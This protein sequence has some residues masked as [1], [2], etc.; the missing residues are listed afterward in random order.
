MMLG[1]EDGEEERV[2]GERTCLGCLFSWV[3]LVS[4]WWLCAFSGLVY[5]GE[6][7]LSRWMCAVRGCGVVGI[8][9]TRVCGSEVAVFQFGVDPYVVVTLSA[10]PGILVDGSTRSIVRVCVCWR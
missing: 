6:E 9:S 4:M 8:K 5:N 3:G 2:W 1:R 7:V 10:S